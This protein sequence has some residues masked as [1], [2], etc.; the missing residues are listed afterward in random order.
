[1]ELLPCCFMRPAL[2]QVR[3]CFCLGLPKK[4]QMLWALAT[5]I[6][7]SLQLA[8]LIACGRRLSLRGA[9]CR[10]LV[11]TG[12]HDLDFVA[13]GLIIAIFLLIAWGT[14]QTSLLNSSKTLSWHQLDHDIGRYCLRAGCLLCILYAVAEA[15]QRRSQW[16]P[17][18]YICYRAV[19]KV[20][21]LVIII[22]VLAFTFPHADRHNWDEFFPFGAHGVFQGSALIFFAY[23]EHLHM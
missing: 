15:I 23:G 3:S 4:L 7:T 14:H 5:T 16:W 9:P 18:T 22:L 21:N 12:S 11:R 6:L 1:M 2:R 20:T 8:Q 17:L 19:V 10:F 13:F